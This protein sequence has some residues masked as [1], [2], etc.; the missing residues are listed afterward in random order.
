MERLEG[1][2]Y[3]LSGQR[4]GNLVQNGGF[5]QGLASWLGVDNVGLSSPHCHE[6]LVAAAMGK[7]D[8][9]APSSMF[10]DVCISPGHVYRLELSVAGAGEG[11]PGNLAVEVHWV[12]PCAE[13]ECAIGCEEFIV[14]GQTTGAWKTAVVYT[15]I[16]PPL[17]NTARIC[18]RRCGGDSECDYLLVD[19][20]IFV[21]RS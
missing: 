10:Q 2:E 16:V 13:L 21:E 3:L 20:V 15:D 9:H 18:L 6:G 11:N 19:D 17:T 1:V 14:Q 12:G 8:N 4:K 7:P 5:E